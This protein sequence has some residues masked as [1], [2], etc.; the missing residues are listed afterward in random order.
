MNRYYL[1]CVVRI[2]VFVSKWYVEDIFIGKMKGYIGKS[3][4]G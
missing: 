3:F 4:I 1:K 2:C